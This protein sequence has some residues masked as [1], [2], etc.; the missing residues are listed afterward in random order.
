MENPTSNLINATHYYLLYGFVSDKGI[1][2]M[3]EEMLRCRGFIQH[4]RST[5]RSVGGFKGEQQRNK[6]VM[7]SDLPDAPACGRNREPIA[8]LMLPAFVA[9]NVK[10][11]LEIGSGTGQ[12]AVF[13][14]KSCPELQKWQ[15]GDFEEYHVGINKW[16]KYAEDNGEK[17]GRILPPIVTN[18]SLNQ[19]EGADEKY[20]AIFSANTLHIMGIE[21]VTELFTHIDRHLKE[22]GLLCYYGPFN[23]NG[24]YTSESN[25]NFDVWLKLRDRKSAIR[26]FEKVNELANVIGL[27]L[28]SDH[29][30]PANNRLLIWKRKTE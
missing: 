19:W 2:E 6:Q 25:A 3:V 21:N 28:L 1:S 13:F 18:S 26:D 11:V 10:S 15:T 27:E 9:H 23:Y 4:S 24:M 29:E 16:I 20:D 12:H 8:K 30:M 5:T 7:A 22:S 14:M 17:H